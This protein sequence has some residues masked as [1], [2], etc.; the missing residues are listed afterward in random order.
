MNDASRRGGEGQPG[1]IERL[2]AALAAAQAQV[3]KLQALLNEQELRSRRIEQA[4]QAWAQTVDALAQPIFMHDE[5]G[6]IVRANRAYAERAGLP[7]RNV[8]GKV[9]WKLFPAQNA[10]FPVPETGSG[11]T[12]FEFSLSDD[13]VFLVRSAGASAGLPPS[14]RL[15]IFQDITELKR[16]EAAVRASGQYAKGIVESSLAVIVAVDRDRRILEFNPAAERAF[17]YTRDEVVG[18]PVNMLYA[19]PESGDAIR[20]LVFERQGVVSE[21]ENRR[22]NGE[23]FT[24][25]MSAA[26]LRDAEGKAL[27]ILGTSI[28]VT[29]RKRAE[30][31]MREVL[32]ELELVFENAVTGIA[33]MKDRVI[34]RVNRRFAE[35]FGYG[36]DELIGASAEN[37]HPTKEDYEKLGR[38][39]DSEL[40][41]GRIYRTDIQLKRKDG[42]LFW[43]HLAGK[44]VA[45]DKESAEAIWVFEDITERK[46]AELRLERRETYFRALIENSNDVIIV[47]NAEGTV[48]YESQGVERVLGYSAAER[49]GRSSFELV[50]PDDIAKVRGGY[51]RILRGEAQ[52]IAV[53]FRMRHRDGSWRTVEGIGSGVFDL[54]GEKVGIVNLHDVTER[55]RGEQRLLKSMAGAIT[56]IAAAAELRDPYTAGHERRVADLAAAIGREMGLAEERVHGIHLAGVI[57]DI[58]TIH[59]P[60][61]ILV[62]PA[63]LSEI[64]LAMVRTHCQ[65]GHDVLKNIDFP[66]PIA[67]IV[68]QHHEL[69]DGSG[70]PLGLKGEEILLEARILAVADVV[71]AMASHRP[72]RP[73]AVIDAALAEVAMN[74]GTKFD[75]RAVDACLRLFREKGYAFPAA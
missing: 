20:R 58:G 46:F 38:E 63:R 54:D 51:Q 69:V 43:V 50:H 42:S 68:L 53:E 33:F 67:R 28:D 41:Q 48:K 61:E 19:D 74:R 21:V 52:H 17:G 72:Y 15:Y 30:A 22:K 59:I 16:A 2:R 7:I 45:R 65:A 73:A 14:W 26:V 64:E 71:E 4:R 60:V 37:I 12:E 55:R 66:W 10:P 1:E 25:L 35:M 18:R 23:V 31:K 56:A 44:A 8:I 40:A 29:D 13:E 34:E 9:Y 57:H 6:S 75:A 49:T 5:K 70:Y 47:V 11:H 62:K 27:G 32:T 36:K 24:S 3:E 39:A